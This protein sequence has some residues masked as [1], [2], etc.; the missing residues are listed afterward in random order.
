GGV[1]L[2]APT[3]GEHTFEYFAVDF[4][5]VQSEPILASVIVDNFGPVAELLIGEP[6]I[7]A[8][9]PLIGRNTPFELSAMDLGSAE[10][11][12]RIEYGIDDSAFELYTNPFDLASFDDGVR[13]VRF[14]AIDGTGNVG[15]VYSQTVSLDKTFPEITVVTVDDG[16]TTDITLLFDVTDDQAGLDESNISIIVTG[17][18]QHVDS[19][20]AAQATGGVRVSVGPF[21]LGEATSDVV[22]TVT[23]VDRLANGLSS[24][25]ITFEIPKSEDDIQLPVTVMGVG[26]PTVIDGGINIVGVTTPITLAATDPDNEGV[27]RID[28]K[29]DLGSDRTILGSAGSFTLSGQTD[30]LHTIFFHATDGAGNIENEKGVGIVLD[31]TAPVITVTNDLSG[32]TFIAGQDTFI[33]GFTALDAHDPNPV[34]TATLKD[35]EEGTEIPVV[36]GQVIDPSTLDDGQWELVITA[37]DVFVLTS[38][39]ASS[40][41]TIVADA[42]APRTTATV[43]TPKATGTSDGSSEGSTFVTAATGISF[44]AVDDLSVVGDGAGEGIAAT[45]YNIDGSAASSASSTSLNGLSDGAHTITYRSTDLFSNTETDQSLTLYLDSSAP[46][47]SATV[48]G[49][50]HD[51]GSVT[52]VGSGALVSG[53]ATDAGV[54]I[55][56][57]E[58]SLDGTNF[59]AGS[60]QSL[61]EEGPQ[62]VTVRSVDLLGNSA[63]A[64]A[65]VTVDL[66]SPVTTLIV[67]LPLVD[68][69]VTSATSFSLTATDTLSGVSSTELAIDTGAFSESVSTT[70]TGEDGIHTISYRATDNVANTEVMQTRLFTADN[71]APLT[72]F[73]ISNPKAESGSDTFITSASAVSFSALDAGVGADKIEVDV[74]EAGFVTYTSAIAFT[75]EGAHTI[76]YRASD[77][78][79]NTEATRSLSLI[80]DNTSPVITTATGAPKFDSGTITFVGAG[81]AVSA[82]AVDAGSGLS[83]LTSLVDGGASSSNSSITFTTEGAHLVLF[84]ATDQL[85]NLSSATVSVT[86]DLTIPITTITTGTPLSGSFVTSATTFTF[87]ATDALSGV[88]STEHAIDAGA[89]VTGTSTTL[90]GTDGSLTISYRSTDNVANVETTQT[91]TYTL[92]NSAP[93]TSFAISAPLFEGSSTF[94]TSASSITFASTDGIGAGVD[95]IEV[96][97]DE[98]GFTTYSTAFT[99]AREGVHTIQYRSVDKLGNT[100]AIQSLSVIVDNSDPISSLSIGSP[101]VSGS[102]LYITSA[103][104]FILSATDKPDSNASGISTTQYRIDSGTYNSSASFVVSGGDATYTIGYRSVDNVTNEE[105]EKSVQVTLDN[106]A[107]VTTATISNPLYEASSKFIT[108]ASSIS[109]SATEAGVGLEKIE[110]NIDGAG[111]ATYSAA[112]TFSAQG[113]HTIQYRSIDKLGNTEA[114]QSLAVVVDNTEPATALTIGSPQASD[115]ANTYVTTATTFTLSAVDSPT[116]A[117]GVKTTEYHLNGAAF[118]EATS[119]TISGVD[120]AYNIGY[121]SDDNLGNQE[122]EKTKA[123]QLDNT[124]PQVDLA[125]GAPSYID[126]FAKTFGTSATTLTLIATDTGS[127]IAS[128]SLVTDG[129]TPTA[130]VSGTAITFAAEGAHTIGWTA[131]DKLGQK[132]TGSFSITIDNSSPITSLSID[133]TDTSGAILIPESLVSISSIDA[134]VIPVGDSAIE[135]KIDNGVF[136]EYVNAFEIGAAVGQFGATGPGFGPHTLTMRS[137]DKLGNTESE[138]SFA[139]TLSPALEVT[140]RVS[141]QARALL[142][143]NYDFKKDKDDDDDD[144]D[145]DDDEKDKKGDGKHAPDVTNLQRIEAALQATTLTFDTVTSKDSFV[146]AMRTNNHNLYVIIGEKK[147]L[148]GSEEEELAERVNLGAGLITSVLYEVKGPKLDFLD[149]GEFKKKTRDNVLGIDKG[150]KVKN[151]D[152]I[153]SVHSGKITPNPFDFTVEGKPRRIKETIGELIASYPDETA[154][155]KET[156]GAATLHTYGLGKTV[157]FSFDLGSVADVARGDSI[158]DLLNAAIKA[159]TPETG[160]ALADGRIAVE[161]RVRSL[162]VPLDLNVAIDEHVPNDVTILSIIPQATVSG[163][164]LSWI[165]VLDATEETTVRYLAELPSTIGTIQTSAA[166]TYLVRGTYRTLGNFNLDIVTVDAPAALSNA[167]TIVNQ[168]IGLTSGGDREKAEDVLKEIDKLISSP[169]ATNKKRKDAVKKL[170]KAIEKLTKIKDD[171]APSL[172]VS[173]R[174]ELDKAILSYTRLGLGDSEEADDDD[175]DDDD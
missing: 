133:I 170:L 15:E 150:S 50:T 163:G 86:A 41:F 81:A 55:E 148:K 164:N 75:A 118:F 115:T 162:M 34:V 136:T 128:I 67:G 173:A 42:L 106:T 127:G 44:S 105:S 121:R 4:E 38:S 39:V 64:S 157:F 160:A 73:V 6:V 18:D 91:A 131:T 95:K 125:I 114:T 54:G 61:T 37:T 112:I 21:N 11:I 32:Q 53:S 172:I 119:F 24:K 14:R 48:T 66:S 49:T 51:V 153:V 169:P 93:T 63:T 107:P 154:K 102:G 147:K 141:Y 90:S 31:V 124:S 77:K 33:I 57:L 2:S 110:I 10:V 25:S 20:L 80:V 88:A 109:F 126:G 120:G 122:A 35:L 29:I 89:F 97:I 94:I 113:S 68:S 72:S 12:A 19:I 56:T 47:V 146:E 138:T 59:A 96:N 175:E 161:I 71:S 1:V 65:S 79:G 101:Q 167:R 123:V 143:W 40:A 36:S 100:E 3:A 22:I 69:F 129:G 137:I 166:I 145:D 155:K 70:I 46:D 156:N 171:D 104:P 60:S 149:E 85:G 103:T 62:T 45:T 98:A 82:S 74:D 111:F 13:V 140:K 23:A 159:V 58:I 134:G 26:S 152:P 83:Y 168:I 16:D 92:D 5:G 84:S 43:G 27:A 158:G 165:V 99:I 28:Y 76:Q 151:D 108:S 135:Y 9:I 8:E 52:F 30:G 142:W 117:S 87:S 130:Y 132:T 7:D 139:F 78:L 116:L 17:T 174:L 144:N